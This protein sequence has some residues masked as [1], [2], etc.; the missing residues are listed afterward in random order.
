ME[1]VRPKAGQETSLP[2]ERRKSQGR[3]Q[4]L[5]SLHLLHFEF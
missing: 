2:E 5:H 3:F 1:P 4:T